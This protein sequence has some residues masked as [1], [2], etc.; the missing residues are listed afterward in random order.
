LAAGAAL[1]PRARVDAVGGDAGSSDD[2][3]TGYSSGSGGEAVGGIRAGYTGGR[4]APPARVA[5][6]GGRFKSVARRKLRGPKVA[7]ADSASRGALLLAEGGE[8]S[9]PPVS[10]PAEH[11]TAGAAAA[12][13]G[14]GDAPLSRGFSAERSPSGAQA[15]DERGGKRQQPAKIRTA[16]RAAGYDRLRA[17]RRG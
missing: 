6:A 5:A 14:S 9:P 15:H 10:E 17:G 12:G 11:D 2:G 8:S 7:R 3:Y 4:G 13:F 16:A 1:A